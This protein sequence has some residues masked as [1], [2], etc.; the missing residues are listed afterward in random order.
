[1]A[2]NYQRVYEVSLLDD[3]HNYFPALLYQPQNFTSVSDILLYVQQKTQQRFNLFDY[4]RRQYFQ[5][6]DNS[7][8]RTP[9]SIRRNYMDVQNTYETTMNDMRVNFQTASIPIV[10][11]PI[12]QTPV[13]PPSAA[14]QSAVL[15]LLRS[16]NLTT[17]ARVIRTTRGGNEAWASLGT[18]YPD[19]VVHATQEII[20]NAS[21][22]RMLETD[23][24]N[25]CA[26]CQDHMRQGELTRILTVC[27]H[28]FHRA[29][30]DNWLLN[31]SVICPTCRHDIREPTRAASAR[32]TPHPTGDQPPSQPNATD[33]P[34]IT[35]DT[36][37]S[38]SNTSTTN[39]VR[40]STLRSRETDETVL[41]DAM[42]VEI[43]NTILG[44]GTL[45]LGLY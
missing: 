1:M 31:E 43:L 14:L 29:C 6:Q 15:P 23:I 7:A 38:N 33:V 24:D 42:A 11:S 25:D 36:G 12:L 26:I 10:A 21:E 8:H 28:Q 22:E 3:I 5:Q 40:H 44:R 9:S 37:I 27:Q 34:S 19:V 17:P 41:E 45:G 20:N 35:G 2:D 16:L 39:T 32:G 30:I 18:L 4:G 13:R